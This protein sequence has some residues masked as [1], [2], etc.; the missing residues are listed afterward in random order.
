MLFPAAKTALAWP[1][2]ALVLGAA[3]VRAEQPKRPTSE[4]VGESLVSRDYLRCV[5]ASEKNPGMS[6]CVH[7]ERPKANSFEQ[8]LCVDYGSDIDKNPIAR[9]VY[10]GRKITY[11]RLLI[12]TSKDEIK[13]DSNGRADE[14]APGGDG[15]I[16][17]IHINGSWGPHPDEYR[18]PSPILDD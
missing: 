18:I 2:L 9:C 7:I 5:A 12:T 15:T 10:K 13:T 14:I 6:H 17:L 3:A 1:M 8:L 11:S 16:D 4:N